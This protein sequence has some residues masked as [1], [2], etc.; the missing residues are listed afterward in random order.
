[1]KKL[2]IGIV[3][4]IF[5]GIGVGSRTCQEE[6]NQVIDTIQGSCQQ[7]IDTAEDQITMLNNILR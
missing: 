4:G 2:S 7:Y 3:V 1:M 5:I 6:V